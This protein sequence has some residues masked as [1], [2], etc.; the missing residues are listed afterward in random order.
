MPRPIPPPVW[1]VQQFTRALEKAAKRLRKLLQR[2]SYL[3]L[4]RHELEHQHMTFTF[5]HLMQNIWNQAMDVAV[6]LE[7][8]LQV[9]RMIE[10]APC[11][12]VLRL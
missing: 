11:L 3:D 9:L 5:E 10:S 12:L 6:D 4:L 7:Y 1:L 8:N 2:W